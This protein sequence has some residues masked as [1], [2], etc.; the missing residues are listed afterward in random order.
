[1][2]LYMTRNFSLL[3]LVTYYQKAM[4]VSCSSPPT[5]GP[6]EPSAKGS[7]GGAN[8]SSSPPTAPPGAVCGARAS[9]GPASLDL[10]GSSAPP[11]TSSSPSP[12]AALGVS[13]ERLGI[14]PKGEKAGGAAIGAKST[15]R[16]ALVSGGTTGAPRLA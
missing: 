9:A 13:A 15:G 11:A 10:R 12:G 6:V 3:D 1:M 5:T 4:S 14:I 7:G 2:D 16:L 8:G